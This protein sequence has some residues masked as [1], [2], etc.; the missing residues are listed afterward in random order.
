MESGHS[1]A[2]N[3]PYATQLPIPGH[4]AMKALSSTRFEKHSR[5]DPF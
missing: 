5:S 4:R 1:P 3:L 2:L